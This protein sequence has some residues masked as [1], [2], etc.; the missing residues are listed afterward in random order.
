MSAPRRLARLIWGAEVDRAL[1]PL[2]AVT[3]ATSIAGATWWTFMGIWAID[4]LEAK[5][6]LPFAFAVGAVFA[7]FSGYAGGHLSDRFGRRRLMLVAEGIMVCYPIALI[8]IGARL[9]PGLVALMLAGV[10]GGLGASVGQAL[11]ADLVP[12]DKH[13]GAYAAVRVASNLGVTLGPP[14]GGVLLFAGGWSAL[15]VGVAVLSLLAW[16]LAFR[17][18]PVRGAYAPE[19]APERGSLGVIVRDRPFLLF[20]GSAVFAWLVY[21]AYQELM[22][23]ALVDGYGYEPAAWG[24]LVIINPVLVTLLQMRIT[25][26][27]D[28]VAAAPKL[29]VAM[30]MMGLPFLL[31][32][33]THSLLVIVVV[34]VVFVFGEMLWVPTSQSVVARLAPDDIRGAYMGAFGSAPAVGFALAPLLGLSVRNAYGDPAM[35][36]LFAAVAVAGAVLGWVACRGLSEVMRPSAVLGS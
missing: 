25:R 14:F 5:E 9:W 20:L 3:L 29:V 26:S 35:W 34:I 30:L 16:A 4:R 10:V 33:A 2:L 28:H 13:E 8:G 36:V 22:P 32:V 6:Q 18:L 21:V 1:R 27:V 24:F 17:L 11:V 19:M 31:L 23:I 12:P 7:A 15:F